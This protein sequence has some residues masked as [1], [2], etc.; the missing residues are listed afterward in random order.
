MKYDNNEKITVENLLKAMAKVSEAKRSYDFSKHITRQYMPYTEKCALVKN[1]IDKTSYV[2][3][4]GVR[5]YRRNTNSMFFIFSIKIIEYYTNIK[6][7]VSQIAK[8]YD[9]LVESGAMNNLMEQIP[10][11][12]VS[13]LQGMLDMERD[14]LEANTRSLVAYLDDKYE[15]IRLSFDSFNK[16]LENLNVQSKIEEIIQ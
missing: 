6:I 5:V 4:D 15:A 16:A 10:Q 1:I 9:A 13:I 7:D 12:E 11:K 3:S 8:E 2:E 14:D